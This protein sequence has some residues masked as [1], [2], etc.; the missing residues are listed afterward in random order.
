[1]IGVV[2]DGMNV[3]LLAG[4]VLGTATVPA[5]FGAAFAPAAVVPTATPAPSMVAA[6]MAA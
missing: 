1:L 5:A 3:Q 6:A 4:L 2:A